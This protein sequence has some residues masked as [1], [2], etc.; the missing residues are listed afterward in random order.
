MA[1]DGSF[2][3]HIQWTTDALQQKQ[4]LI[5]ANYWTNGVFSMTCQ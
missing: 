4:V 2:S 3:P 1:H 5:A